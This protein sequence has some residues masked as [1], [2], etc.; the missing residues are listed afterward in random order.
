M[1]QVVV[2]VGST[3]TT[4]RPLVV[5]LLRR[6]YVG[7]STKEIIPDSGNLEFFSL[8]KDRM[9]AWKIPPP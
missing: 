4:D 9:Y 5:L 2:L 1:I 8:K 3:T 6:I 7:I